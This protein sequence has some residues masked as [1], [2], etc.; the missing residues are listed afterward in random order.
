[1]SGRRS[2]A[3]G[4]LEQL[5]GLEAM[6]DSG[7]CDRVGGGAARNGVIAYSNVSVS[8]ALYNLGL[9]RDTTAVD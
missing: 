6:G 5:G 2:T 9:R 3:V 4:S 8:K 1:M 7:D